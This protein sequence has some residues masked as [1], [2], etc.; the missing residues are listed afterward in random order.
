MTLPDLLVRDALAEVFVAAAGGDSAASAAL[1]QLACWAE[2]KAVGP[3]LRDIRTSGGAELFS[4]DGSLRQPF[5]PLAEYVRDRARRFGAALEWI[6]G[7]G[8]A[9]DALECARAAWDAGLFFEVHEILEPAWMEERGERRTILQGLIMASAALH[10]LTL[11]NLAGARDLLRDAAQRLAPARSLEG[12]DLDGFSQQLQE[13]GDRIEL[14]EVH[15][16]GD[17]EEV[18]RLERR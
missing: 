17:V 9:G 10:H 12:L 18:P 8:S 5:S 1:A 7:S 11:S 2:G 15:H 16:A 6:R 13:L 14:G 4:S 3:A